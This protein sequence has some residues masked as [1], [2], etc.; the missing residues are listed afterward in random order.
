MEKQDFFKTI[1][2]KKTAIE[3]QQ[4]LLQATQLLQL[5]ILNRIAQQ[6]R[7]V[8]CDY[9]VWL[10]QQGCRV[11]VHLHN[12]PFIMVELMNINADKIFMQLCKKTSGEVYLICYLNDMVLHIPNVPTI[13]EPFNVDMFETY[14]QTAI[15]KIL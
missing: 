1:E 8:F 10:T 7:N 14:L 9:T 13:E 15:S 4:Q 3:Q 2:N 6:I 12:M 5:Q 11:T